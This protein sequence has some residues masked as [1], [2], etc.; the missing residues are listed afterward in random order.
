M[1]KLLIYT[2]FLALAAMVAGCSSP[3]G[4]IKGDDEGSLVGAKTAG[5]ATYNELV[6]QTV[7][8]LLQRHSKNKSAN[9]LLCFV[10]IEN[11]SSEELGENREALYEEIDTIIVNSGAYR[12]VSR[13][14]VNTALRAT[15]MRAEDIFLGKGR[16]KFMKELGDEGI[17]PTHLMWGKLTS[18]STEGSS[19]REREYLL[20]LEIVEAKSGLTEA[21]QTSK[22]RKEYSK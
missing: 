2:T 1:K 17:T 3:S 13:R 8:K 22:V 6:G 19:R 16:K 4:R 15:G 12:N 11:R 18:I 7:E 9:L 5:A 10:E 20:T 21:K 14:F